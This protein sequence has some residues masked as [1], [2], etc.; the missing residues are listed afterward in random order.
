MTARADGPA[1]ARSTAPSRDARYSARPDLASN[2]RS[3]AES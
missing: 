2:R 1:W 3:L